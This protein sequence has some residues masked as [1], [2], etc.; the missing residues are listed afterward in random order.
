[1]RAILVMLVGALAAF[2]QPPPTALTFS[3]QPAYRKVAVWSVSGCPGKAVS[4]AQIRAVAASRGIQWWTASSASQA[5][6]KRTAW[7]IALMIASG[8]AMAGS[9]ATNLNLVASS[10]GWRAG[11][12]A[13][14]GGLAILVPIIK[15]QAPALEP[16]TDRD[17]SVDTAGCGTTVFY[18]APSAIGP[19]VVEFAR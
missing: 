5:L 9:A 19:F 2:S 6:S 16:D 14:A 11:F 13:A 12:T 4:M 10:Q 7:G 17:L 3:P 8:G 1:M 15:G 18:A